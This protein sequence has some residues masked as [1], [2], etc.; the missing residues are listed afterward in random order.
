MTIEELKLHIKENV[1]FYGNKE[2]WEDEEIISILLPAPKNYDGGSKAT[3]PELGAL[4]VKEKRGNRLLVTIHLVLLC[5][6][7][8]M[9]Q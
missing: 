9:E 8:N 1:V 6:I 4:D 7:F 2:N 3:Y 5:K